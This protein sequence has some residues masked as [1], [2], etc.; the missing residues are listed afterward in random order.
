MVPESLL[1][2]MLLA[3]SGQDVHVF[4]FLLLDEAVQVIDFVLKPS[5]GGILELLLVSELF[6]LLIQE[7]EW[8]FWISNSTD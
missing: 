7:R 2:L 1:F 5:D 4:L 8:Y 6:T 3:D